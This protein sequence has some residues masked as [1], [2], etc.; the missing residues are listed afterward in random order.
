MKPPLT[1]EIASAIE[2]HL[3]N[4]ITHTD[5]SVV[6]GRT[7]LAAS[8]P[9]PSW[10]KK[11]RLAEM[12]AW[13]V[14]NDVAAGENFLDLIFIRI[15]GKGSFGEIGETGWDALNRAFRRANCEL[16]KEGE[17]RALLLDGLAGRAHHVGPVGNVDEGRRTREKIY[18]VFI[19]HASEDKDTIVR[20]IADSLRSRN[21]EVWYDEFTL[22]IGD[23]LR[24]KIDE[25]LRSSVVGLV[26]LSPSF[27]KK[28]WTR[29][30]LNG[31][32]TQSVSGDQVLIPIWHEVTAQQVIDYSPSLADI[33]A[34]STRTHSVAEIA[35]EIAEC[36]RSRRPRPSH[37]MGPLRSQR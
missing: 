17:F 9:G 6:A 20:D 35:D 19:S 18:D 14:D 30:E 36:I 1:N 26:V 15:R 7:P 25:G 8:D 21:L 34:R 37:G 32:V 27:M 11:R 3:I 5:L 13:A 4:A 33:V 23:S 22:N 16:T 29:Y 28:D 10:G 12:L 2:N 31:I 24:Q